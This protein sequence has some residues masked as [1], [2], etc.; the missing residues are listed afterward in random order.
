MQKKACL[1]PPS[2]IFDFVPPGLNGVLADDEEQGC[3]GLEEGVVRLP[4][5]S[6][7]GVER[8]PKVDA[9]RHSGR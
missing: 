7:Q 6:L 8:E 5:G 2:E 9:G 1:D 3:P 4:S